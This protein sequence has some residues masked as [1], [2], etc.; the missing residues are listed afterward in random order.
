MN[1]FLQALAVIPGIEE[2]SRKNIDIVCDAFE[3]SEEGR[4]LDKLS[5]SSSLYFLSL[6]FLE[7]HFFP[8]LANGEEMSRKNK[9]PYKASWGAQFNA[10]M[11]RSFL[12]VIKE[13]LIVKVR[14]AQTIVS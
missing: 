7:I 12:S 13:P 5:V 3:M 11:W 14:I 10:L 8:I 4:E 9:S 1:V 6:F 2:K